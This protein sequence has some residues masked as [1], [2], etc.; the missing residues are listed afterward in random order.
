MCC[1]SR[2][3][4]LRVSSKSAI[5]PEGGTKNEGARSTA[6][7]ARLPPP[8][9]PSHPSHLP[10]LCRRTGGRRRCASWAPCR[11]GGA[12]WCATKGAG[13]DGARRGVSRVIRAPRPA[14][15]AAGPREA[16]GGRRGADARAGARAP[17]PAADRG[18]VRPGRLNP[19]GAAA[20]GAAH[21]GGPR[22]RLAPR[23]RGLPLWPPIR[24]PR[25]SPIPPLA[26]RA[27][28]AARPRGCPAPTR[29]ARA[30][31]AAAAA[32][33]TAQVR[34]RGMACL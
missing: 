7:T 27:T 23:W 5:A 21:H 15:G 9:P 29:A 1:C 18:A 8:P 13:G 4:V 22:Q 31:H 14:P 16:A 25:H 10:P 3:R 20:A 11:A 2:W 26:M 34:V 30:R 24:R 33:G 6:T 17:A 19:A 32:A 12:G 28:A